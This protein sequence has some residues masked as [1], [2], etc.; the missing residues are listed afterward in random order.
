M[1][2]AG[3]RPRLELV[4]LSSADGSPASVSIQVGQH[5]VELPEGVSTGE[6]TLE[7]VTIQNPR[8]RA[9]LGCLDLLPCNLDLPCRG[10]LPLPQ[11]LQAGEIRTS[12]LDSLHNPGAAC[13]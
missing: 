13:L 9:F 2:E 6:W 5:S 1:Q 12:G 10:Y 7:K 11:I 8:I 4:S 3:E